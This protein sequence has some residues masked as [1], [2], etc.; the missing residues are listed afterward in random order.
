MIESKKTLC[1]YLPRES[2]EKCLNIKEQ[3]IIKNP[4]HN[5]EMES[6]IL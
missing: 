6:S 4:H 3:Q 5:N 2:Y 1:I